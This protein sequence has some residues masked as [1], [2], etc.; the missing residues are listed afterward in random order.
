MALPPPKPATGIP[1]EI[2]PDLHP[3]Y[4]NLARI[5]HAPAEFVMDFARLLPGDSK[6]TVAA[7]V[8]MSP[9]A[10]KLF[11]QAVNENLARY[12]TTFGTV[13]IP[14]GGPSLADSLFRPLHPPEPPQE[15][16]KEPNK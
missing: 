1:I 15:P 13:N 6:A 14:S 7:R 12:E 5:A 9:V 11:V 16:P 3:A 4:A 10:L 8:I 2:P